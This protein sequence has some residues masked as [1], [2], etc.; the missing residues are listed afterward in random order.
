[1]QRG[2]F[3]RNLP[4]EC[5][6][7]AKSY[8]REGH[9]TLGI[10]VQQAIHAG[11]DEAAHDPG[12]QTEGGGNSEQVGEESAVVPAEMAVGAG[13]I[14][15]G[16]APAGAGANDGERGVGDGGFAAGGFEEDTTVISWAQEAEAEFGGGEVIDAGIEV[17]E[18]TANEIELDLIERAGAGGGAKKDFASGILSLAGEAC[19]EVE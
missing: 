18:G 5:G 1:M 8:K 14:F 3:C 7:V 11:V 10:D 17:S 16:V 13:L 19:G 6:G 2:N 4:R 12:R 9:F 15:P